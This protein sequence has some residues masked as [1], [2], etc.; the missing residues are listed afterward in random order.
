MGVLG[1]NGMMPKKKLLP[2]GTTWQEAYDA[3]GELASSEHQDVANAAEEEQLTLEDIGTSNPLDAIE[4]EVLV[5]FRRRY[6]DILKL[7]QER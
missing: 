7:I 4:P 6:H 3:F 5:G 2:D 1:Y